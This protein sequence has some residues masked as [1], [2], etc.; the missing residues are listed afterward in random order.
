MDHLSVAH[1]FALLHRR[2]QAAILGQCRQVGISYHGYSLLILLYNHE[3]S[4]QDEMAESLSLDKAIVTRELQ[5][6]EARGFIRRQRDPSDHRR[7][8]LYLTPLGWSKQAFLE[9]ALHRWMT[10]LC[11]DLTAEETTELQQIFS[12][13]ATR[14]AEADLEQI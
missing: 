3:G 5:S 14:A 2:S 1:S 10:Y 9:S 6:L 12:Q 7:K 8:R 11:A 13:L 4:S